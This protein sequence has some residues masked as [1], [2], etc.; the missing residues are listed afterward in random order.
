MEKSL[1]E[2]NYELKKQL[3]SAQNQINTLERQAK[4]IQKESEKRISELNEEKEELA[5][6]LALSASITEK[7]GKANYEQRTEKAYNYNKYISENALFGWEKIKEFRYKNGDY[8]FTMRRNLNHPHYM[9]W[10]ENERLYHIICSLY[11]GFSD[12][13]CEIDKLNMTFKEVASEP[14]FELSG[15]RKIFKIRTKEQKREIRERVNEINRAYNSFKNETAQVK[16][17]IDDMNRNDSFLNQIKEN[18]DKIHQDKDYI[19]SIM[20][21]YKINYENGTLSANI[22]AIIYDP[23]IKDVELI[24][25]KESYDN[26]NR[27]HFK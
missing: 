25:R 22:C 11:Y 20:K 15:W 17:Y 3:E 14:E 16:K 12:L 23:T 7:T 24:E 5:A 2:Q 10:K 4:N 8:R 18:S 6:D 9:I 27:L 19:D 26:D 21:R 1:E 13:K